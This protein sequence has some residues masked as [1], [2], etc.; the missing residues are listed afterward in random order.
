MPCFWGILSA[1]RETS[2]VHWCKRYRRCD[3][4]IKRTRRDSGIVKRSESGVGLV[5]VMVAAA[6]LSTSVAGS[7][8]LTSTSSQLSASSS[9]VVDGAAMGASVVEIAQFKPDA[10]YVNTQIGSMQTSSSR[11]AFTLDGVSVSSAGSTDGV[12]VSV[13]WTNPYLESSNKTQRFTLG[14]N[15]TS[16]TS[17]QTLQEVVGADSGGQQTT[18]Y[19]VSTS[20]GTGTAISPSSAQV[21]SGG[22]TSFTVTLSAGYD[23]LV[24]SGC[25]GSLVG[26]T[27]TTGA[28]TA[29]CTIT[30]SATEITYTVSTSSGTGVA[31][32]SCNDSTVTYG[33]STTCTASLATGYESLTLSGCSGSAGGSPYSTGA[34]YAD[35]TVSASAS[36]IAYTV[37]TSEGTGTTLSP[38]SASVSY[39]ATTSFTAGTTGGYTNL[40]VSGCFGGSLS[41]STFTT[42][43]ITADCTVTSS[44]SQ[45][46]QAPSG[47]DDAGSVSED[48]TLVRDINLLANDTDP[49]SNSL[50]VSAISGGNT[51][52]TLT[53]QGNGVYR[54]TLDNTN[55]TVQALSS[56]QTLS[57]VYTYTVSD[58][59]LTDTAQLTVTIN[60]ADESGV[61]N[62]LVTLNTVCVQ[63]SNQC[64][65]SV[66]ATTS[67]AGLCTMSPASDTA[68]ATSTCSVAGGSNSTVT[69]DLVVNPNKK[70]C[71][72]SGSASSSNYA[73]QLTLTSSTP[74]VTVRV[75]ITN[76]QGNCNNGPSITYSP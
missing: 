44:A 72:G 17:F 40:S 47:V 59:S 20:A 15:V 27:Y 37:S 63:N 16:N 13:S 50:S 55:S 21:A 51:Y 3:G 64:G 45:S 74:N 62:G 33:G 57:E 58:G 67:P 25:G 8:Y 61:G 9:N 11:S 52:G 26:N 36:E 75:E 31:S 10:S 35:C 32:L 39:G 22:S 70:Y 7:I 34:I 46:N 38:S 2:V 60:G 4:D 5:E 30:A 28:I 71:T 29:N 65:F 76:G 53:S 73:P 54:Y 14:S 6:I 1:W 56:S 68:T 41:G 48:G 42:G 18:T 49:E 12:S 69:I 24:V 23:T 19:T 43:A 66:T